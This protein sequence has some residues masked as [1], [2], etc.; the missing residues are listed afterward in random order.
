MKS[1]KVVDYPIWGGY[2]RV[3]VDDS[4]SPVD[5]PVQD[6]EYDYFEVPEAFFTN[7]GSTFPNY[8][9]MYPGWVY[10]GKEDN[11]GDVARKQLLEGIEMYIYS[12]MSLE[13]G[14]IKVPRMYVAMKAKM[15]TEQNMEGNTLKEW[16][17]SCAQ[18]EGY[19]EVSIKCQEFYGYAITEE[20]FNQKLQ[21][22]YDW[23]NS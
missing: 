21:E 16:L 22:L 18:I 8:F 23:Y 4:S 5:P 9:G 15:Q 17:E 20:E 10:A 1:N 14:L 3:P 13:M 19:P 6:V 11:P 7:M 2:D 12:Q